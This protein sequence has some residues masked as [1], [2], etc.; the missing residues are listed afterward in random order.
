MWMTG[1][2][3]QNYDGVM[4]YLVRHERASAP[5]FFAFQASIQMGESAQHAC[6]QLLINT[7]P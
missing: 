1:F 3:R 7:K 5:L 2:E 4:N 6:L